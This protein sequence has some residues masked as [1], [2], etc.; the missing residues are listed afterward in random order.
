MYKIIIVMHKPILNLL[1]LG[2]TRD[3]DRGFAAA[4]TAS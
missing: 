3:A 4:S 2:Q 1:Q